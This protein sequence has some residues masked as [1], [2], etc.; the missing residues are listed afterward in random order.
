M[1]TGAGANSSHTEGPIR[2]SAMAL[3]RMCSPTQTSSHNRVLE[4]C[5]KA[6]RARFPTR[7]RAHAHARTQTLVVFQQHGFKMLNIQL[8][9]SFSLLIKFLCMFVFV[10]V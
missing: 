10:C 9:S 8:Q 7:A 5:Q 4:A 3:I 1:E 2:A 6:L